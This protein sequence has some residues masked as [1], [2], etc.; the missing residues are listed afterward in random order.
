MSEYDRPLPDVNITSKPFWDAAKKH[1]LMAYKCQNCGTHYYPLTT[2]MHCDNPKMEWVKVSG[3]GKIYTFLVYD[4]AY[5]PQWEKYIPYNVSWI[6][7]DEGPIMMSNVIDCPN[8]KLAIDMPV[9]VAFN[10]IND[11]ISLPMFKPTK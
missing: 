4:I 11:Q 1:E 8:D 6:Q 3:K 2:C 10:D 5:N 9:E 7:L